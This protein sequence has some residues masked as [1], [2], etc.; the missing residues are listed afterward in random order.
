MLAR[1]LL[2]IGLNLFKILSKNICVSAILS[3][4]TFVY[5]FTVYTVYIQAYAY[6][7]TTPLFKFLCVFNYYIYIQ[8]TKR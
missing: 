2:K 7:Y 6:A 3:L 1:L 5:T 8:M 4:S